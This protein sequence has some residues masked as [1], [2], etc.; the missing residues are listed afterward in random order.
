MEDILYEQLVRHICASIHLRQAQFAKVMVVFPFLSVVILNFLRACCSN[1]FLFKATAFHVGVRVEPG[2]AIYGLW[3][4]HRITAGSN[5]HAM[6]AALNNVWSE[7][8][9]TNPGLDFIR[10]RCWT[11]YSLS[12]CIARKFI[13]E[14]RYRGWYMPF[15]VYLRCG[16]HRLIDRSS[17]IELDNTL[18]RQLEISVLQN[19]P[20]WVPRV[21]DEGNGWIRYPNHWQP[22]LAKIH[23]KAELLEAHVTPDEHSVALRAF[24]EAFGSVGLEPL[25]DGWDT[26]TLGISEPRCPPYFSPLPEQSHSPFSSTSSSVEDLDSDARAPPPSHIDSSKTPLIPLPSSG[27]VPTLCE[28][29]IFFGSPEM[30]D[31]Y[32]EHI[33]SHYSP[34]LTRSPR[35]T[36]SAWDGSGFCNPPSTIHL[37]EPGLSRED[38]VFIPDFPVQSELP[39]FIFGSPPPHSFTSWSPSTSSTA[40]GVT[41]RTPVYSHAPELDWDGGTVG[42][43][44]PYFSLSMWPPSIEESGLEDG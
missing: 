19:F 31:G 26:D 23:H 30:D 15:L 13:Q 25:V 42:I 12:M 22:E 1:E 32:R 17:W 16:T 40:P 44:N 9:K 43:D 27:F 35:S 14:G 10:W 33:Y 37:T 2:P 6:T 21:V 38:P 18:I 36:F 8:S 11:L 7:H 3:L 28:N 34:A 24:E 39:N 4:L 5:A 29:N 41:L 20:L